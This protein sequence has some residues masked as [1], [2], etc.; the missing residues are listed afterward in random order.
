MIKGLICPNL[1]FFDSQGNLD[2]KTLR[3]HLNWILDRGVNGL[4]VTGTY[5]SGYLMSLDE[6]IRVYEIAKEVSINH[7]GT[8]VIGHVGT[9]DTKSSVAL[10]KA[11][12]SIGLDAVS[13]VNPYTYKY[14]DDELTFYYEKLVKCAGEMP[15]LAYNNPDLTG[16]IIDLNLLNKFKDVGIFGIKDSTADPAYAKDVLSIKG[17]KYITGSN[18]NWPE[19]IKLGVDTMISGS[20]NYI[21]ELIYKLYSSRDD[22]VFDIYE[23]INKINKVVKSGNS[24]IS[25]HLALHSRGYNAGFTRNPLILDYEKYAENIEKIKSCYEAHGVK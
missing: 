18:K 15:V 24:I 12:K 4:F 1:T 5:G 11:A 16:K 13:A 8:F 20:S 7:P 17:I 6:R 22:S 14:T 21:P 2:E 9:N 3:W 19:M 25:S 23:E 10:T